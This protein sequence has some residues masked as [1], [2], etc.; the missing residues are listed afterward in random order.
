MYSTFGYHL[1]I[2]SQSVEVVNEDF[3][4][5]IADQIEVY[6]YEEIHISHSCILIP[7]TRDDKEGLEV[8]QFD[9]HL[10]DYFQIKNDDDQYRSQSAF[11]FY[12]K[13]NMWIVGKEGGPL[14]ECENCDEFKDTWSGLND[15]IPMYRDTAEKTI[16][17]SILIPVKKKGENKPFGVV[18]FESEI[19]QEYSKTLGDE[20]SQIAE[21]VGRLHLRYT[22]YREARD[23]RYLALRKLKNQSIKISD[24]PKEKIF[25]GYPKN[26]N[27]DVVKCI[28][29]VLETKY[30]EI[31]L[32]DWDDF[33]GMGL[34][35]T[36]L[37][38]K[39]SECRYGIFYLSEKIKESQNGTFKY[40]DNPNVFFEAGF[41]SSKSKEFENWIPIRESDNHDNRL[42]F[43]I[44]DRRVLQVPRVSGDELDNKQF[45]DDLTGKLN[46]ILFSH[47]NM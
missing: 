32:E 16:V 34:I 5:R 18:A 4:L 12:K 46:E 22:S 3:L 14:S 21:A 10:K 17:S 6:L 45:E 39:I 25:F 43:Y 31:K 9:G 37:H 24:I 11:S 35:T 23:N 40:R 13:R 38:R 26:A 33:E 47:Q 29:F 36:D 30:P 20:L 7:K 44:V 2:L 27:E 28:K 42:P 8:I 19:Y 1:N 15:D 41:L